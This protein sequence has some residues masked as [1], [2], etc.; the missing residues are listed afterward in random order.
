MRIVRIQVGM[1]TMFGDQRRK[2]GSVQH[3]QQ[4]SEDGA[5]RHPELDELVR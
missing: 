3:K 1:Q 5:L 4:W 2:I